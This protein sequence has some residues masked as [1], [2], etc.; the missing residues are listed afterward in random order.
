MFLK[1]RSLMIGYLF[2]ILSFSNFAGAHFEATG[3]FGIHA[4]NAVYIDSTRANGRGPVILGGDA[5]YRF[6]YAR[7][8]FYS[9]DFGI[10]LRYQHYF[11]N[12]K[13]D[14]FEPF[15]IES[16][17]EFQFTSSRFAL[18]LGSRMT[19][20]TP[21]FIGFIYV[22]DIWKSITIKQE[23]DKKLDSSEW[24]GFVG[25]MAVELGFKF[26]SYFSVKAELGYNLLTVDNLEYNEPTALL[27]PYATI[28]VSYIFGSMNDSSG[29]E[30]DSDEL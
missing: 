2:G 8:S 26:T 15:S 17:E 21:F 6:I 12:A 10:G 3:N 24:I 16:G 4:K 5:L 11:S 13:F 30:E 19:F 29:Y 14:R 23:G 28:G 20:K 9:S 1:L 25:Q 18:L 7:R 27:K 22:I